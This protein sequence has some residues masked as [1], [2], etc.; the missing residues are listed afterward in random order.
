MKEIVKTD[1]GYIV[2]SISLFSILGLLVIKTRR[3]VDKV[4]Q[5]HEDAVN[6]A[7]SNGDLITNKVKTFNWL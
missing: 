6:Y 4:Y 2:Y 3:K 1:I 5:K 7:L